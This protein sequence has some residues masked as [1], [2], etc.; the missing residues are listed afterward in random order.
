MSYG[1]R[2]KHTQAL[3]LSMQEKIKNEAAAGETVRIGLHSALPAAPV[4]ARAVPSRRQP[5]RWK[6]VA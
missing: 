2:K 6:P 3:L 4:A 5:L 1:G